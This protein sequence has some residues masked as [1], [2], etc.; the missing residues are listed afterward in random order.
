LVFPIR[1]AIE[2]RI[3]LYY[4]QPFLQLEKLSD[5]SVQYSKP[6]KGNTWVGAT[7]LIYHS[8]V[9][10]LRATLNYFPLQIQP[11]NFQVSFG[12]VLFNERA[13]R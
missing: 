7:S 3:D 4:Y 5:G 9:G 10:P 11:W 2:Y 12:Y 8:V 1:K 13:V 6:F